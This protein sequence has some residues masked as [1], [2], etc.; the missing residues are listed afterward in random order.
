MERYPPPIFKFEPITDTQIKCAIT[1]LSPYKATGPSGLSNAV[2]NHCADI[3][4]SHLG[5]IYKVMFNLNAFLQQWK[6][7]ITAVLQKLN[8]PDYTI[9]K[10]Y[11][12]TTLMETL[13][14]PLSGCV[15]ES[16][17]YQ[18]EKHNLLL[19][20][21]SS[22]HPGSSTVPQMH[23]TLQSSSSLINGEKAM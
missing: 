23:C 10:A 7:T 22:G 2:L 1:K 9:A 11:R 15:A 12:P 21:N 6:I 20:T 5:C 13:A 19:K 4:T 8:K 14:K 16:L 17:S 18:A 3:L